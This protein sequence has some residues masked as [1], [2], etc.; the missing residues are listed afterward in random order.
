MVMPQ[1]N[2]RA[3]SAARGQGKFRVTL[4]KF[5]GTS[6]KPGSSEYQPARPCN[7]RSTAKTKEARQRIMGDS[8]AGRPSFWIENGGPGSKGSGFFH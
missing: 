6:N 4:R 7:Q 5:F 2:H 8:Q 1:A 3:Q